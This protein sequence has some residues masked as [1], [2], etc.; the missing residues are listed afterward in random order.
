MI[1]KIRSIID[2]MIE[3][4][5]FKI[6]SKILKKYDVDFI[7]KDRINILTKRRFD[8][9]FQYIFK[10]QNSCDAIPFMRKLEEKIKG[11]KVC[12]DVGANIG[13]TTIWM[14]RNSEKV[15]AFEPESNNLSRL[16]E[17]LQ[18]NNVNN[19]EIIQKV[20]SDKTGIEDFYL[21]NSY[22]HHSLSNKHLSKC[23]K[24]IKMSSITLDDFV[25]SRQIENIDVLKIDVEGFE[26]E[27]L[28]GSKRLL[29]SGAIKMI[30]FEHS[31]SLLKKQNRDIDEV[32][33]ILK[34]FSYQVFRLDDEL[35]NNE[36][37]KFLGQEDLYAIKN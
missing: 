24:K 6:F 16:F 2:N 27:V 29:N 37:I 36:N 8:D 31:P 26:L 12:V 10:T 19:V 35:V 32:L 22:G 20:V 34:S 13:I 14:A 33:Q 3:S 17:N 5:E 25:Q 30:I 23:I 7:Y 15:Y 1:L 18:V 9:N 4:F 28:K 21:M 11:S